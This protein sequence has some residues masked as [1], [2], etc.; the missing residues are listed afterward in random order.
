MLELFKGFLH[1]AWH[2]EVDSTIL[3]VPLQRDPKK[4]STDPIC[5]NCIM[6]SERVI[7]LQ[8]IGSVLFF[9]GSITCQARSEELDK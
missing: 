7:Q 9:L 5:C 6:R 4:K 8:Q 2:R 3:V 1:V